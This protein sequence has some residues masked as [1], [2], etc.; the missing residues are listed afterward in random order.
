M[1]DLFRRL[2]DYKTGYG[3]VTCPCCNWTKGRHSR[4][5]RHRI[6]LKKMVRQF[7]KRDLQKQIKE[8]V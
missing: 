7:L 3:G 6:Q 2:E 4:R 8:A 5:T 1:A